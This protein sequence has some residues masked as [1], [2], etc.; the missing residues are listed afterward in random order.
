[1]VKVIGRLF[2]HTPLEFQKQYIEILN[3]YKE[4]M[5]D[6]TKL[7]KEIILEHKR[8]ITVLFEAVWK[9]LAMFNL[10]KDLFE[11][12]YFSLGILN[13]HF[14]FDILKQEEEIIE[15][16]TCLQSLIPVEPIV[17][18]LKKQIYESLMKIKLYT[19]EEQEKQVVLLEKI[20]K[21]KGHEKFQ[22]YLLEE[23]GLN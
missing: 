6:L 14:Y 1:M 15:Y 16:G 12:K 11:Q 2:V 22:E 18:P 5:L 3:S 7:N 21:E 17:D 4:L 13:I 9:Y 19:P 23:A 8:E 10:K 20:K